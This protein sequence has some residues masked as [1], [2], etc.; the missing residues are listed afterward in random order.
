MTFKT[1]IILLMASV[2]ILPLQA[3]TLGTRQKEKKSSYFQ[4]VAKKYIDTLSVLYQKDS[5]IVSVDNTPGDPYLYPLLLTPTLYD[6]PVKYMMGS[7]W[8]PTRLKEKE[9]DLFYKTAMDAPVSRDSIEKAMSQTLTWAYSHYPELISNTQDNI[10]QAASIRKDIVSEPVRDI[11]HITLPEENVD[12]GIEDASYKVITRKPNFWTFS[13]ELNFN[14]SQTYASENWFQGNQRSNTYKMSTS[15]SLNYNNQRGLKFEN[16]MQARLGFINNHNDTQHKYMTNDDKLEI[17]SNIGISAVKNWYYTVQL[18][19]W[20][21]MYP[22]YASNSKN[23]TSDFLS[24]VEGNLSIGMYYEL[25]LKKF[26]FKLNLLPLSYHAK[27]CDRALLRH[28]YG[29]RG[30]HHAYNDIGYNV[31]SNYSWQIAKN[32]RTSGNI[33]FYSNAHYAQAWL[34]ST[35]TFSINKYLNTSIYLYPRFDDTHY[36]NG[37]KEFFQFYE[38]LG[39]G[40]G[41]KF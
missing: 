35:T 9:V 24:P 31:T 25:K 22:K 19:V 2:A 26:T 10:D 4:Q 23:V 1:T 16:R 33:Y 36:K 29:I 40:L 3:Q 32:I 27:Y 11:T 7:Q 37:K 6:R 5:T 28:N 14:M 17:W 15:M 41:F 34:E 38:N 8:K 20:T 13:G 30:T 39:I 18:N 12:T 21:Q